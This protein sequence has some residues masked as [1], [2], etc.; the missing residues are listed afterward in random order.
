MWIFCELWS[1]FLSPEGARKNTSNEQT[2]RAY[3]NYYVKLL[4]KRFIIPL[5][6]FCYFSFNLMV[7]K[8]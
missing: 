4:N 6:R 1:I 2:I 3:Y 5:Q 7:R 8:Y